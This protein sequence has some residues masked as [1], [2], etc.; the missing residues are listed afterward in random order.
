MC[1]TGVIVPMGVFNLHGQGSL[2]L[3]GYS[4]CMAGVILNMHNQGHCSYGDTQP[5]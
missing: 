3:Q 2:F 4:T 1:M 5:A